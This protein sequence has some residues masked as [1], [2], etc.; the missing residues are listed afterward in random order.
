MTEDELAELAER[1]H[2]I[3]E[4]AK[5]RGWQ[6][7]RDRAIVDMEKAQLAIL[8]G[9]LDHEHYLKKTGEYAGMA[10]VLAIPEIVRAELDSARRAYAEDREAE[11]GDEEEAA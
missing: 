9:G 5:T 3:E 6:F 4:F 10:R 11:E 8:G 2:Q 1:V 7:L